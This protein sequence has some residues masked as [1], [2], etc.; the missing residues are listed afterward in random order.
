[1]K[2]FFDI[3]NFNHTDRSNLQKVLQTIS[4]GDK[5]IAD[6]TTSIRDAVDNFEKFYLLIRNIDKCVQIGFNP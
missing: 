1:M 3:P 6:F 4:E 5:F 2:L